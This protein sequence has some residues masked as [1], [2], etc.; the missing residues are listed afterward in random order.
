MKDIVITD[1]IKYIGADDKDLDLFESQYVIPNGV[2]Y[3]SYVILDEKVAVMDTIDQRRTD[4]WL[5]NLERELD[6]RNVDYIVVSH[7]EPDH[8]ASLQVLAEKYPE[9]K[10]IGNAKTFNMIPQFFSI[11]N[12]ADRS[13]TVKEGDTVSLGKHTLQFFMAPMVHW[14]EVMVAYEQSEKILFSA[15]GFG[16][17]GALDVDEDWACEAR[18]YYFNIVGK[19]G[20]QVQALLKKAA[21]LD[22][23]MICP[24]HGPIL[25][26][27]LGYYIGLYD[28]WSKYEPEDE[29]I[30]IAYASIHGNTGKAAKKFAEIL[31]AKG[32]KK[33]VVTDLSRDD[34]AEAVEDAFRYDTLVLA[35]ATYDGGLFPC[36]EDFL[37]H[38]KAKNYQKRKIAFMENGSWAPTAAKNMKAIVE[39][40][41]NVELVDP[42][43]TIKSTMKEENVKTMEE[44]AD[45]LLA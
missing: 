7:L 12:L 39:N 41:K 21:G 42:V 28:T 1:A 18:R 34:M 2:S 13:V 3:N 25:K 23:Q 33:V 11:D 4:E 45:N 20:M 15:D 32:A 14:P 29:G 26:E 35:C 24:L 8:A 5:A 43:V 9:A 40:F 16:K 38:L 6:G 19:Y 17:F 22:I 36:M 30:V 27:N 10:L 31:E 44:L 37:H